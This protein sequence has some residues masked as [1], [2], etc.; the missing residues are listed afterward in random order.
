MVANLVRLVRFGPALYRSCRRLGGSRRRALLLVLF[1]VLAWAL[2]ACG[3]DAFLDASSLL[4]DDAGDGVADEGDTGA[5]LRLDAGA[6]VDGH[7]DE[8]VDAHR[9]TDA[10]AAAD[11]GAAADAP[12]S[13][14]SPLAHGSFTCAGATCADRAS[15]FCEVLIDDGDAGAFGT[16]S[17]CAPL[18]PSCACV[19][20]YSCACLLEQAPWPSA[21]VEGY[22]RLSASCSTAAALTA[23]LTY[24]L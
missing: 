8:L 15:L 13:S 6:L 19:E 18:P 14:C 20:T 5:T 16:G 22:A 21:A 9:V 11:V 24:S 3:G 7:V 17:S 2:T 4:D 23:T 1:P 12:G 10:I